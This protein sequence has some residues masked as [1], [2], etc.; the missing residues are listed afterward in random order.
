M[1]TRAHTHARAH[2][3]TQVAVKVMRPDAARLFHGDVTTLENFCR[4]AQP[5][6]VPI[7]GEV[8]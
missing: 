3:H 5:Q 8:R 7:F 6:I 4:L 2:T 1:I